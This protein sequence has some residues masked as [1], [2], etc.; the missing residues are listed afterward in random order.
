MHDQSMGSLELESQTKLGTCIPGESWREVNL[1]SRL[2]V[3][4]PSSGFQSRVVG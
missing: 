2:H 1:P 3:A 4:G